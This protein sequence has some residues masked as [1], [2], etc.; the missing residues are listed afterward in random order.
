MG[1]AGGRGHVA[2]G[3][4]ALRAPAGRGCR[5][6]RLARPGRG[7]RRRRASDVVRA[8][9]RAAGRL[10]QASGQRGIFV[11]YARRGAPAAGDDDR[12]VWLAGRPPL[13][14]ALTKA[15]ALPGFRGLARRQRGLGVR[16]ATASARTAAET[17]RRPLMEDEDAVWAVDGV[18][19]SVVPGT[20]V[21]GFLE[22]PWWRGPVRALRS[23]A[24]GA[25]RRWYVVARA[26]PPTLTGLR[27]G[28]ARAPGRW[29]RRSRRSPV[30]SAA[31]WR[32]RWRGPGG[33]WW[34]RPAPRL[35]GRNQSGPGE[36]GPAESAVETV[37]MSVEDVAAPVDTTPA[38]AAAGPVAVPPEGLAA[39]LQALAQ[40]VEAQ[41][42]QLLALVGLVGQLKGLPPRQDRDDVGGDA[43]GG[44]GGPSE[45]EPGTKRP[46]S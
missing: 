37:H 8:A 12:I 46:R 16:V 4:R 24:R 42:A 14:E 21:E 39:Q 2:A 32:G 6:G 27:G 1:R 28:A 36:D 43:V 3:P 5:A 7:G 40:T 20:A 10:L 25:T 29:T 22:Q 19:S 35:A 41:Q 17:L 23:V 13:E 38:P 31:A 45:E 26:G 44:F 15:R 18:P 9:G 33:R 34:P 11:R 30:R